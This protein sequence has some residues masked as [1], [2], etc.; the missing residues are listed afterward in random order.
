MSDDPHGIVYASD[1]KKNLEEEDLYGIALQDMREE[2]F[3]WLLARVISM[4]R[5]R[6]HLRRP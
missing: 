3:D 4:G 5:L 1:L 2:N 6:K